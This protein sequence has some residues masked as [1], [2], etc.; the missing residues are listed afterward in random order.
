MKPFC[1]R[2]EPTVWDGNVSRTIYFYPVARTVWE[3][4]IPSSAFRF[5]PSPPCGMETLRQFGIT[6]SSTIFFWLLQS[7]EP[8]VWDGDFSVVLLN[9]NLSLFQA[10]RVGWRHISWSSY[11]LSYSSVPSPPCGMAT[12]YTGKIPFLFKSCSSEPTVWDGDSVVLDILGLVNT[13]RSA[14]SF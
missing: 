7:S 2:S 13:S 14:P 3:G 5:V 6:M 12:K 1:N 9:R 8:T 4:D 11:F 10:H